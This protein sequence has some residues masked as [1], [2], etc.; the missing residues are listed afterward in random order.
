MK[1]TKSELKEMI[2]EVLRE[3]LTKKHLNE[4]PS[5]AVPPTVD[6][7]ELDACLARI[8]ANSDYTPDY[9]V[10]VKLSKDDLIK[11][12][13]IGT[14]LSHG[15]NGMT[16]PAQIVDSADLVFMYDEGRAWIDLMLHGDTR[17]ESGLDVNEYLGNC[18][19]IIG[20]LEFEPDFESEEEAFE[21]F[22]QEILPKA[23]EIVHNII[24]QAWIEG[25]F[26]E[27]SGITDYHLQEKLSAST[28]T[29]V[30]NTVSIF[31]ALSMEDSSIDR[32]RF[33]TEDINTC[34]KL[35][36][37]EYAS[38]L[39][40]GPYDYKKLMLISTNCDD[41]DLDWLLEVTGEQLS[42]TDEYTIETLVAEGQVLCTI[43]DME[44]EWDA[45]AKNILGVECYYEIDWSTFDDNKQ[46]AFEKYFQEKGKAIS[47]NALA[48]LN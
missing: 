46:A 5:P 21:Y 6:K 23:D 22:K 48:S 27:Y 45:A 8:S 24:Q 25:N 42:V 47:E 9:Y 32:I 20:S 7:A 14:N 26:S 2:R 37:K 3:E 43:D 44:A 15:I 40:I 35:F 19:P 13:K 28:N 33:V 10:A 39:S 18:L 12:L 4:A 16:I 41:E 29:G 17:T 30:S 31:F 34:K 1:I 11:A 38:F 36:A